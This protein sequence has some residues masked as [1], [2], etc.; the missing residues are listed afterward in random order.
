MVIFLWQ[1][2]IFELGQEKYERSLRKCWGRSTLK[3]CFN[4]LSEKILVSPGV[5][6]ILI[7]LLNIIKVVGYRLRINCLE[8]LLLCWTSKTYLWE[9][10]RHSQDWKALL[11]K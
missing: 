1:H 8:S 2:S 7:Q 10:T 4:L 11:E 5:W 3:F 6:Q 9:P